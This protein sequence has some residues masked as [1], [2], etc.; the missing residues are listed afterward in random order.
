MVFEPLVRFYRAWQ[1]HLRH[2]SGL[3]LSDWASMENS[4]RNAQMAFGVDTNAEMVLAARCL[5]ELAP[6][7]AREAENQ[8]RRQEGLARRRTGTELAAEAD[9]LAALIRERMWDGASGFFYDLRP[10]GTRLA[11]PTAA[12]FWTLLAGV[13]APEQAERLG[14]WLRDPATFARPHRIPALAATAQ[15][16]D[17]RGGHFRGGVFPPLVLMVVRGLGRYGLDALAHEVAMSHVD[18]VAR[19]C[20]ETGTFWESYSAEGAAPGRPAR[21]DFV[22]WSAVGPILLLL[23]QGVGLRANAP[24]RELHWTV[25]TAGACGCERYWFAGGRVDV[26]AEARERLEDPLRVTVTADKPLTLIVR[27]GDRKRSARIVGRQELVV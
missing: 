17:P 14:A 8:G 27:T 18:A 23:E 25:R 11:V 21:R 16:Y 9:R 10:D 3:Y 26:R 19:V 7:A 13:A 5:A 6:L 2:A 1:Q 4:P 15:G 22:G 24:L 12:A 20:A